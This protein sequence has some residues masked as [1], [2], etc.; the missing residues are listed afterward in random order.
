M[1]FQS[2]FKL[3][4]I[5]IFLLFNPKLTVGCNFDDQPSFDVYEL[6]PKGTVVDYGLLD[7]DNIETIE[8]SDELSLYFELNDDYEL[9]VMETIDRDINKNREIKG[10]IGCSRIGGAYNEHE[11]TFKIVLNNAVS[12]LLYPNT[13]SDFS[14]DTPVSTSNFEN[15][16]DW[17]ASDEDD[18]TLTYKIISQDPAGYFALRNQNRGQFFLTKPI[19]YEIVKQVILEVQA[20]S[21]SEAYN[22]TIIQE[23]IGRLQVNVTDVDDNPPMFDGTIE[24]KISSG[25]TL[26]VPPV[27]NSIVS[28]GLTAGSELKIEPEIIVN[29]LDSFDTTLTFYL[30]DENLVDSTLFKIDST[31]G[32]VT[33]IKDISESDYGKRYRLVIIVD[34]NPGTFLSSSLDV[35]VS[36]ED[37]NKPETTFSCGSSCAALVPDP[38]VAGRVINANDDSYIQVETSDKDETE[39]SFA[40]QITPSNYQ[41]VD[42]FLYYFPPVSKAAVTNTLKIT[43]INLNAELSSEFR[44]SEEVELLVDLPEV[45]TAQTT[46]A[47]TIHSTEEVSTLIVTT[48]IFVTTNIPTAPFTERSKTTVVTDIVTDFPTSTK[49]EPVV[50]DPTN[51][52]DNTTLYIV[53]GVLS[54]VILL[55]L[56][57]VL[58]LFCREGKN[59]R[60]SISNMEMSSDH[61]FD[62]PSVVQENSDDGRSDSNIDEDKKSLP[63]E[64]ESE[65]EESEA[66]EENLD[67]YA[68]VSKIEDYPNP[69]SV[70]EEKGS[71]GSSD[72]NSILLNERL[73]EDDKVQF[74]HDELFSE[75]ETAHEVEEAIV[76]AVHEEKQP[77][78]PPAPLSLFMSSSITDDSAN[79]VVNPIE[80]VVLTF[81]LACQRNLCEHLRFLKEKYTES[82]ELVSLKRFG[83]ERRDTFSVVKNLKLDVVEEDE[84][85]INRKLNDLRSIIGA[86]KNEFIL[87]YFGQLE[88]D[89]LLRTSVEFATNG[90]LNEFF[91]KDT[92]HGSS[93][94][95]MNIIAG[96]SNGLSFIHSN[97]V[98]HGKL[99]SY[100]IWIDEN[101]TPKLHGYENNQ[102]FPFTEMDDKKRWLSPEVLNEEISTMSSDI[103]SLGVVMWEIISGGEKPYQDLSVTEIASYLESGKTLSKPDN[104][105]REMFSLIESG[106]WS[107]QPRGRLD[108][109][110]VENNIAEK[111]LQ[112]PE[113]LLGTDFV[114]KVNFSENHK[115]RFEDIDEIT[116]F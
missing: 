14:E 49:D 77:D 22:G 75:N 30:K 64:K 18:A 93:R 70:D 24:Y 68:T 116:E 78:I 52:A 48:P 8:L 63:S 87:N 98:V 72:R 40:F 41:I 107:Y 6:S 21:E 61:A 67:F 34:Q 47:S 79:A 19:D 92:R 91:K 71:V 43:S 103:W 80:E 112:D 56:F 33:S 111:R 15:D 4:T 38:N 31:T 97:N 5:F 59:K 17:S 113:E 57:L 108:A 109:K 13:T 2:F 42:N 81:S 62:N 27:Y 110:I 88:S 86:N 76:E 50:I 35:L 54:A 58:Y 55:L 26:L 65:Y 106:C 101:L 39:G 95:K 85:E 83:T 100:T 7:T 20:T 73:Q 12:P 90:N 69:Y 66:K 11:R 53:A 36:K 99:S 82:T 102:G 89:G 25:K 104:C 16:I 45:T 9:V 115:V 96:I 37:K 32:K 28:P 3:L 29:D 10:K 23:T 94:R 84:I 44:T 46:E 114:P 1:A 51:E 105:S 74:H 60:N